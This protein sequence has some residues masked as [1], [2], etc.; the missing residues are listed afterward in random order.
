M[1]R[2]QWLAVGMFFFVL[3]ST[4]QVRAA[5]ELLPRAQLILP[6][7]PAHALGGKALAAQ[8]ALLSLEERERQIY[9]EVAQGN[10]P[11]FL[12]W[13]APVEREVWADGA[14][15]TV[16]FAVTPDYLAVGSDEDFL[17]IPATPHLAQWICDRTDCSLPT[18]T[19]VDAICNA[20]AWRALPRPLPPSPEMVTVET[21]FRHQL[22]IEEQR[23]Q[24]E[25]ALG[26]LVS[27]V[28]K[29]IV[30]TPQ[31]WQRSSPPR[32]AIY[33][34]HLPVGTAIQPLSLVHKATY[35]DYSHGIRLVANDVLV[36]GKLHRLSALLQNPTLAPLLSDE[37]AFA[38]APRYSS[39]PRE[40][41]V[42]VVDRQLDP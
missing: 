24:A 6:P 34:W 7:R 9:R 22:M 18:R 41:D 21:F 8:F 2:F 23:T 4:W 42:W 19:M 26:L 27:G 32:V 33:G 37:G 36:D 11:N 31:L 39:A 30:L 1:K 20:A 16:R 25:C 17:R 38:H 35:A 29:D 40:P 10:V 28:K 15:S 3:T 14:K 12:R 13:L 5:T